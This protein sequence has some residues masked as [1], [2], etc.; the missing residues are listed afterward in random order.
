MIKVITGSKVNITSKDTDYEGRTL[1]CGDPVL[2]PCD[3]GYLIFGW[4][5]GLS[6]SGKST[7]MLTQSGCS[8]QVYH[9]LLRHEWKEPVYNH[10]SGAQNYEDAKVLIQ[11]YTDEARSI[12]NT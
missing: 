9:K 7:F 2:Y 8:R 6:I 5:L 4:Y 12:S 10:P 11:Q 1:Y 3:K